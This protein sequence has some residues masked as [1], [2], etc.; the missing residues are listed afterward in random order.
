MGY[1][2]SE[3][4]HVPGATMEKVILLCQDFFTRQW[5][6]QCMKIDIQGTV[7]LG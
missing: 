2:D 3:T 4:R 1:F 7:S 6:P 5:H